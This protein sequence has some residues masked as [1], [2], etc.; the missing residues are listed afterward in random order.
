MSHPMNPPAIIDAHQHFWSIARTDYGWLTPELPALYRDFQPA[1]LQPMRS[2]HHVTATVLVQAAPTVE[3]TRYMLGLAS[4][5]S[6]IQGV[7]GWVDLSAGD[8][9]AVIDELAQHPAFKG[10]RPML[11]DLADDAWI[12]QAPIAAAVQ[13]LVR[14]GL[15]FDALVK[16]RHLPHLLSFA[17]AHGE[18]PIV[19][20]HAAK[21]DIAAAD[22]VAWRR[23]LAS[24]AALPQ[25]HIKL[26]GLVTEAGPGWSVEA[27][28]PVVDTVLALF[29]PQ[30]VMWGSDW[31]VLNLAADYAQ[32]VGAT[33]RLL[34]GL[35][36]QDLHAVMGGNAQR[37]YR[38]AP[39]GAVLQPLG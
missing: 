11:Q 20:D 29:G 4:S 23:D 3:E 18:L 39:Q 28:R 21:P 7:V 8:A 33:G 15:S 16:P 24:L 32:W 14:R 31:P 30:R 17:Q 2:A 13:H 5:H 10:V 22:F 19:I 36:P 35:G 26:S 37:F 12:A 25:V 1:D 34:A 6:F 38:L 9:P 27:L